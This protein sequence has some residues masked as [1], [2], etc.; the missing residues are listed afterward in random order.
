MSG[1]PW[2]KLYHELLD[3]P[4]VQWLPDADFKAWIN[5]L[6]LAARQEKEGSLPPLRAIAYAMRHGDLTDTRTLLSRLFDAGLIDRSQ[7]GPDGVSYAIHSWGPRQREKLGSAPR[8][9]AFRERHS[10]ASPN[11][12]SDAGEGEG[13]GEKRESTSVISVTSDAFERFKKSYPSRKGG[14]GWGTAKKR[15]DTLAR[16]GTDAESIIAAAARYCDEVRRA[17]KHGTEFVLMAQTWINDRWREYLP[18]KPKT[19]GHASQPIPVDD[20]RWHARLSIGRDR[21]G[22]STEKWG[23]MPGQEGSLVP[24]HL[25]VDGD[26]NGWLEWDKMLEREGVAA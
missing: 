16:K 21:G 3:D 1:K 18:A 23:P 12:Q 2:F 7:G 9:K 13:E 4:K 6:C 25:L 8:M 14:Q 15:F 10:D 11:V 20:E 19:N 22:W 24:A 26:G 17:G 5:L